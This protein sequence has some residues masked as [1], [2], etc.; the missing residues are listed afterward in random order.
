MPSNA[1]RAHIPAHVQ[2]QARLDLLV[3]LTHIK[4]VGFRVLA[5]SQILTYTLP[6]VLL[7]SSRSISNSSPVQ[8]RPQSDGTP[9]TENGPPFGYLTPTDRPYDSSMS[10]PV[11]PISGVLQDNQLPQGFVPSGGYT[12]ATASGSVSM[13]GDYQGNHFQTPRSHT[14]GRPVIPDISLFRN[15][16][17][18]DAVSSADTL[19]TPPPG[20]RPPRRTDSETSLDTLMTP[21]A[22]RVH[23]SSPLETSARPLRRPDSR[24]SLDTLMTPPPGHVHPP[25]LSETIWA[26]AARAASDVI[27]TQA[28]L[29]NAIPPPGVYSNPST[30]NNTG[31]KGPAAGRKKGKKR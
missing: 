12:P 6:C 22:G 5:L 20:A 3:R 19:S 11:A 23:P 4:T 30:S 26:G 10:N 24:A 31:N 7:L 18:D 14:S 1:R 13:P 9:R 25:S 2:A 29:A 15:Y 8:S 27:P 17:E 16:P 21:P 28:S